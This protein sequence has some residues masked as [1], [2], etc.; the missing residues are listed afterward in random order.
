MYNFRKEKDEPLILINR[1][2]T[3]NPIQINSSYKPVVEKQL[4]YVEEFTPF[5]MS[6]KHKRNISSR[7]FT[8]KIIKHENIFKNYDDFK[9]KPSILNKSKIKLYD[10][11]SNK[12]TKYRTNFP[13]HYNQK[14]I[15]CHIYHKVSSYKLIWERPLNFIDYPKV[16]CACFEG[17]IETYHPFKFIAR[18]A[19]KDLLMAENAH[20]KIL[21]ILSK[22]YTY[23]QIALL[24]KDDET[25][26]DACDICLLLVICAGQEG[27]PYM[28]M[29][30]PPFQKR[31]FGTQFKD[32]IYEILNTFYDIYGEKAFYI[33]KKNIP[34]FFPDTTN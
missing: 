23:I 33:I 28:Q 31:I 32:K 29:I 4:H 22:L 16:L 17:L 19:C 25:F 8:P 11:F 26:M 34:S 1:Y 3:K 10:L 24:D 9:V 5:I 20:Q 6:K 21:P 2:N 30:F 27:Y 14:L 13:I 18:Q 12:K 7:P 15:P